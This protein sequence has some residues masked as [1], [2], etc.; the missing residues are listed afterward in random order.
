MSL[1]HLSH[2]RPATV[3]DLGS[4]ANTRVKE[5]LNILEIMAMNSLGE[6]SDLLVFSHLR[7]DSIFQR[8]Q[9]LLSRHTKYRRVFYFEEPVFGMTEIPRLY[10]RETSENVLIIIPYLPSSIDPSKME[11]ALMDLVDELIYEEELIDYSLMYYDPKAYSFS[12]HL[13]PRAIIFDYLKEHSDCKELEEAL[14]KRADL[15]LTSAQT[16]HESKKNSH[17]NIHLCPNGLDLS[18]FS[19]GRLKLIEPD[20]QINIPRPRIGFHGIIDH[21]FDLDFLEKVAELRPDLNFVMLGPV[22]GI[23][24]K[25]LPK[26]SNI[27]YLGKKDYYALPLYLAGWDCAFIPILKN[28]STHFL[29][30]LEILEFLAAGKPVIATN[31]QE[32]VE[33]YGK[34][35]L[36]RLIDNCS[37]F[38]QALEEMI[39]EKKKIEWLDRVDHFLKESSWEASFHKMMKLE[40]TLIQDH[41]KDHS[42]VIQPV[43]ISTSGVN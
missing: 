25:D 43:N 40:A 18:H 9:H 37:N 22:N 17:H 34:K 15:V 2:T 27:H 41:Q 33:T 1:A 38:S 16:F 39:E 13:R 42:N 36:I 12:R 10:L 21:H 20:D 29:S 19:Q 28:D 14:L 32:I 23:D 7:W 35:I 30:P 8:P 31:T 26:R 11:L 24:Q 3:N 5:T 6:A 4:P